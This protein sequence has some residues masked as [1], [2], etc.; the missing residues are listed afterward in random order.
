MTVFVSQR[1]IPNSNGWVP[2]LSPAKKFGELKYVFEPDDKLFEN[3]TSPDIT[4]K[5]TEKFFVFDESEDFLLCPIFVDPVANW[6]CITH[7]C[8]AFGCYK[9]NFL[10]WNRSIKKGVR[11]KERGFYKPVEIYC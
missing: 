3:S 11:N 6:L 10:Y 5:L 2:D 4:K 7:L 1:P 8:S 9:I